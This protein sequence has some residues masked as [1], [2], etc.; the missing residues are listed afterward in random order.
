MIIK[1]IPLSLIDGKIYFADEEGNIRNAK[2]RKRKP[3]FCPAKQH[4]QGGSVY[5]VVKIADLNRNIHLLV[6]AAF[7]GERP[8]K[9]YVCHHLD[10]NKF[11]NRPDNLIWVHKKDHPRWDRAMRMG[12]IYKHRDGQQLMDQNKYFDPFCERND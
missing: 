6:C 4:H 9:D 1:Q 8:S 5:P 12:V 10:G 3:D 11:N 2:G 7:W